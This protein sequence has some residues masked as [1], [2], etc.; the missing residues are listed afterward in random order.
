VVH[1][2]APYPF[3]T[4]QVPSGHVWVEGD[5]GRGKQS[6]D[7]NTY[8]PISKNLIT[9]KITYVMWPWKSFGPVQWEQFK[10]KTR[11]IKGQDHERLR[12]S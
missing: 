9:G 4:M 8:G 1:T 10:G 2:R 11:V 6:V 3:P 7:S 5:G 12:W